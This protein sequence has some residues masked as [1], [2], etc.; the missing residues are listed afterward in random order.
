MEVLTSEQ[1]RRKGLPSGAHVFDIV[2]DASQCGSRPEPA[3]VRCLSITMLGDIR[4]SFSAH[5]PIL[6]HCDNPERCTLA[7]SELYRM[8]YTN[9]LRYEGEV[10]ALGAMAPTMTTG[11]LNQLLQVRGDKVHLLTLVRD[12]AECPTLQMGVSC[13]EFGHL[14]EAIDQF[15]HDNTIVMRCSAGVDPGAAVRMIREAGFGDVRL[16]EG[17]YANVSWL[18]RM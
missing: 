16:F 12:E 13:V 9:V 15:A 18:K 11:D 1:I 7:A 5:D 3:G 6:I 4:G 2:T 17:D 14:P 10:E 8:G